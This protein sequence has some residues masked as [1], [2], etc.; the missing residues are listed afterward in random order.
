MRG[1]LVPQSPE[2]EPATE[3]L[4]QVQE[5]RK[6]KKIAS[7]KSEKLEIPEN[8][9]LPAGWVWTCL[10]ELGEI[11]PKNDL[12][13]EMEVG[14][15]PMT[16][17]PTDYRQPV[18]YEKRQWSGIKKGFTHFAN[19]DVGVAKITPC[20]QNKKSTVF[21]NLPNHYGAGTTELLIF[22]S[23]LG[24]ID[25]RYVLI[26]LKTP[27][28]IDEG[29]LRMTGTAGQQRVPRDYFAG[30]A[31]PL[32]PLAEQKRI[33][34]KVDELMALCDRYQQS[35]ETQ[36]KLRQKLR[37]SAIASLMNA[38]TDEELQ[39]SWSIVRDNWRSLSQK[40]E[41]VGDLR[42]SILELAVRGKLT[43]QD[44]T[45]QSAFLVANQI[46]HK[47]NHTTKSKQAEKAVNFPFEIPSNWIWLKINDFYD[48]SG[49]IQKTPKR[50]PISNYF[51]YLR[52][53]NV[54][55]GYL[56]LDEIEYFELLDG[57]LERWHLESGDLLIVEGNGSEKEIGRC[58][59]WNDQI[60]QCVHQNHII[61]ARPIAHD[62]QSFTLMFLNS[63]S[64]M[65]EMRSLAITTSG[66]YSLSVG[67]IREIF[68]PFP[69]LAE[70]K[71]IVAKVDE[72]MQMCDLLEENL[73]QTQ[74]RVEAL[75]ASAINHLTV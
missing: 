69:P 44:T 31:F 24:A 18:D 60:K 4:K 50:A 33:V 28:F 61:R 52:V 16:L 1:K 71:R 56:D 25:P 62:S 46:K 66:L 10:Q 5:I 43:A 22:R 13:D 11:N 15:V 53:A 63:P 2:D 51:P 8:W 73:C 65:A 41:D 26:F 35:Q 58:A 34:E 7:K 36:D 20:F 48:V 29:V 42:R 68:V 67:K 30:C 72:L 38:E 39:K 6:A 14:F 37:G 55:R 54:Q 21:S 3:L 64:G 23:L 70:Q 40:P 12:P 47:K 32:P 57:E 27:S 19:G 75:A 9:S 59:I 17:I 49:G 74:Q 45:D